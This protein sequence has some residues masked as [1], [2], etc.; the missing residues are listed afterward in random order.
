MACLASLCSRS[1]DYPKLAW[2]MLSFLGA[3]MLNRRDRNVP[4]GFQTEPNSAGTLRPM[5]ISQ[6]IA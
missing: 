5:S 4:R 6:P 2:R 1:G 3:E